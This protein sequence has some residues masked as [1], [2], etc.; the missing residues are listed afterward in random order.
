MWARHAQPSTPQPRPLSTIGRRVHSRLDSVCRY[1]DR[2]SRNGRSNVGRGVLVVFEGIDGSGK[3]TQRAML[4][5]WLSGRDIRTATLAQ[6]SESLAGR[7]LRRAIVAQHRLS[8]PTELALFIRDRREQARTVIRPLLRQGVVVLLDRHYLSSVAYQGALGLDPEEIFRKCVRFSPMAD[9]TFLFDIDPEAALFR[10]QK[11]RVTDPFERRDYLDSVRR[12]YVQ[13]GARV[14]NLVIVKAEASQ[15]TIAAG[16]RD[17]VGRLVS[18][19]GLVSEC[20][21]A[22]RAPGMSR[23]PQ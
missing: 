21:D 12:M 22:H 10:I 18:E 11:H 17:V 5:S 20:C 15:Q 19:R 13:W 1:G 3:T 23:D 14:P 16:I 6:P 4:A 8:P 2:P 9:V 7:V